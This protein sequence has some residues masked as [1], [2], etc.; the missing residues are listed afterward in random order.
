VLTL[1]LATLQDAVRMAFLQSSRPRGALWRTL[2]AAADVQYVKRSGK[3]EAT[4]LHFRA[5]TYGSV[6]PGLFDRQWLGDDVPKPD[7]TAFESLAAALWDVRQRRKDGNRFDPAFLLR[8][9]RYQEMLGRE[10][11]RIE[12]PDAAVPERGE[13]D[14]MAILA[15]K[16]LSAGTPRSRRVRVVGRL[17]LMGRGQPALKLEVR[18]GVTL[19]ILWE[20]EQPLESLGVFLNQEVILA[21]ASVFRPSGTLLRIDADAI[22]GARAEDE[23]FRQVPEG[24]YVTES[25]SRPV[26]AS[27]PTT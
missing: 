13:I 2:E 15:A 8:I 21:G 6:A 22:V 4:V 17:G 26:D 3:D 23:P 24:V 16:E 25:S 1:L 7:D 14:P 20:G 9:G 12:M 10:I 5:P 19:A 11:E 18:P 27:Q